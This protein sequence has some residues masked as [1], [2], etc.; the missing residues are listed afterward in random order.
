MFW[1]L[2]A[3]FVSSFRRG[4]QWNLLVLCGLWL[5]LTVAAPALLNAFLA[6]RVPVGER[7]EPAVRQRHGYHSGW[8]RPLTETMN[9]FYARYPEWKD[10][11]VP[12]DR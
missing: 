5:G 1:L 12:A 6:L 7:A 2:A 8:D 4:S 3:L 9:A 11:K 10:S